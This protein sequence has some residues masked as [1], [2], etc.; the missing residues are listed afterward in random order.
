M[1]LRRYPSTVG[2]VGLRHCGG[3]HLSH[4]MKRSPFDSP[5]YMGS[6]TPYFVT[7]S[8]K[9][10]E[11]ERA[12]LTHSL[13]A[14]LSDH[15]CIRAVRFI[16][17]S[18]DK[19]FRDRYLHRGW[20]LKGLAP[21]PGLVAACVSHTSSLWRNQPPR[22]MRVSL[23][24]SENHHMHWAVV[25]Q[26]LPPTFLDK[27]ALVVMQLIHLVLLSLLYLVSP[28]TAHRLAAYISEEATV[29]MTHMINDIDNGKVVNLTAP[30]IA[31]DYWG[32]RLDAANPDPVASPASHS[33]RPP[34]RAIFTCYPSQSRRSH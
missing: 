7:T 10:A 5:L 25:A 31:V 16:R 34:I 12:E 6:S 22:M 21:I 24:E 19:V 26:L 27:I 15:V 20:M 2:S 30:A 14:N 3:S 17:W 8:A 23:G 4:M 33:L 11:M 9:L 28:I 13:P 18:A 32:I 1:H 29:V